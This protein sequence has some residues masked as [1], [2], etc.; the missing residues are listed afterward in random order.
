MNHV[1]SL[2][3]NEFSLAAGKSPAMAEL[4]W[5]AYATN[6]PSESAAMI[7]Y[8]SRY[9]PGIYGGSSL[10][11]LGVLLGVGA[12]RNPAQ[13]DPAPHTIGGMRFLAP[14]AFVLASMIC[15]WS[16]TS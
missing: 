1:P 5:I 16:P 7:Q 15:G 13:G 9:V 2:P 4:I 8:A 11:G 14:A 10:T 3:G 12:Q 6:P